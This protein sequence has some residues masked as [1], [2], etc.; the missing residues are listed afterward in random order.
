MEFVR[1]KEMPYFL[2]SIEPSMVTGYYVTYGVLKNTAQVRQG[3]R[4]KE[5]GYFTETTPPIK[6]PGIVSDKP[7]FS[8][9]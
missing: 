3:W 5:R 4:L 1:M 6:P 9:P 7:H 8:R 2:G